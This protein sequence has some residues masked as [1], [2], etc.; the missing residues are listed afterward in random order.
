MSRLNECLR[1]IRVLDLS[2]YLPGPLA[3]LLLADLGAEVLKI[4][5]PNGDEMTSLGPCGTDG[6]PLF[7]NAINGGKHVRRMDLKD[8]RVREDF[9]VL[10]QHAD[11]LIESSRPGAME[12]LGLGVDV[13]IAVNPRLVHCSL[14]GY[15]SNSP[16][17]Q[18]A[19]HDANY[20]AL[21]GVLRRNGAPIPSY[22]DPPLADTSGAM[23]TAIAILGALRA[24]DRDGRGCR[25]DIGLA[26]AA[27][28]LQ[29]FQIA[30]FGA[31]GYD[32]APGETYL[33]GG[34]AY[35]HVY[36]TSDE[37]HVA[38]AAVEPKFWARFCVAAERQEWMA[39]QVEPLPQHALT[40]DLGSYFGALSLAQCL[41][42]FDADNCCLTPVLTLAEALESDHCH[43]RRLV[44]KGPGGDLQALFP[45]WMDGEPPVPRAMV[46]PTTGGFRDVPD[47]DQSNRS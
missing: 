20:L 4:E 47:D 43:S 8:A 44:V 39:R 46:A 13:L 1:G 16:L 11:V 28:P 38:L 14:S 6:E 45:A 41:A 27:M 26:D 9:F 3:T 5:P 24:R 25:L 10:V 21:A 2:R 42:R 29:A 36:A 7:Y 22:F 30:D 31:R 37:R 35:Y 34:A 23:L 18:A 17:A 33:N 15:G 32:P 40:R 12:R 19:G